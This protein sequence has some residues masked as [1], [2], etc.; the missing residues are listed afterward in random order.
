[1]TTHPIPRGVAGPRPMTA[2][3]FDALVDDAA[4]AVVD[5]LPPEV[6]EGIS[7]DARSDLLVRLSDAIASVL[8]G[9]VAL[10]ADDDDDG[11]DDDGPSA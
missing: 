2:D 3:G 7:E 8:A 10:D 9:A 6:A 1:M 11:V 4:Y 5:L